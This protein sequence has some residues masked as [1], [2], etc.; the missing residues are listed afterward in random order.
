MYLLKKICNSC[1]IFVSKKDD[2]PI[3][4]STLWCESYCF[5]FI[6]G[7]EFCFNEKGVSA[8]PPRPLLH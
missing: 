7:F 8:I 6:L 4:K 5:C 1:F 3:G 2:F